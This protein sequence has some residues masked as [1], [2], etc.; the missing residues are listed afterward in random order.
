[1][2]SLENQLLAVGWDKL[3]KIPPRLVDLL[4]YKVG[5]PFVGYV[6][7]ISPRRAVELLLKR[8][9]DGRSSVLKL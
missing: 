5:A 8:Y 4:G 3:D 1:M 2:R 9:R 6:D 7:G